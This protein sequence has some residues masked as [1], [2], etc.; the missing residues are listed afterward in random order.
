[1]L[2]VAWYLLFLEILKKKKSQK[3]SNFPPKNLKYPKKI[4]Q[5]I[6][7]KEENMVDTVASNKEAGNTAFKKGSWNEA[8]RCY[9]AALALTTETQGED[10]AVLCANLSAA[11][12]KLD[13][14]DGAVNSASEG[15]RYY[16]SYVKGQFRLAQALLA[17]GK[18]DGRIHIIFEAQKAC[19]AAVSLNGKPDSTMSKLLRECHDALFHKAPLHGPVAI[20][21]DSLHGIGMR[22]S[23]PIQPGETLLEDIPVAFSR[24]L[25]W[26][27]AA[28]DIVGQLSALEAK[29]LAWV[30]DLHDPAGDA[31]TVQ[32]KLICVWDANGHSVSEIDFRIAERPK[33]GCA[34]YVSGSRINHSCMPNS[35]QMFCERTGKIRIRSITQIN[36]GDEVTITYTPLHMNRSARH[37]KLKFEC[38]CPRCESEKSAPPTDLVAAEE[39]EARYEEISE[40]SLKSE[41]EKDPNLRDEASR[42]A[43]VLE[44]EAREQ[45]GDGAAITYMACMLKCKLWAERKGALASFELL[46]TLTQRHMPPNFPLFVSTNIYLALHKADIETDEVVLSYLHKAFKVHRTSLGT[47]MHGDMDEVEFFWSRY[48]GELT[49][50]EIDSLERAR[51]LFCKVE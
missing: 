13:N 46:H 44:D 6:R 42:R 1:M 51:M 8:S 31:Q 40:M 35:V 9:A 47:S 20:T 45:L 4:Y 22:A 32:E 34:I 12:M 48:S 49:L 2:F 16:G 33:T 39:L 43:T 27:E 50:L 28:A 7:E 11:L 37:K 14:I 18:R 15:V 23:R 24:V 29:E 3:I 19:N 21:R 25:H 36:A 30:A 5:K 26:Q 10:R 38:T 41:R 17:K